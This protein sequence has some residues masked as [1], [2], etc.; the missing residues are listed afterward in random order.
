MMFLLLVRQTLGK[1][2]FRTPCLTIGRLDKLLQR[3]ATFLSQCWT[4]WAVSC[5]PSMYSR[6]DSTRHSI[7]QAENC[8]PCQS[9]A[10]QC[11]EWGLS[12]PS[13]NRRLN[14]NWIWNVIY[15]KHIFIYWAH[16][17]LW[18]AF[19]YFKTLPTIWTQNGMPHFVPKKIWTQSSP[20]ADNMMDFSAGL[21]QQSLFWRDW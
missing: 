21:L 1:I 3:E 13:I 17:S 10:L 7:Q 18:I 11:L 4:T 14:W 2:R 8:H 15:E 19:C 5:W 9:P 12:Q 20:S 16:T 6:H